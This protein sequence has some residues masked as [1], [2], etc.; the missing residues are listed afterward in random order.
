MCVGRRR[1]GGGE[2]VY[3][4]TTLESDE[5]EGGCVHIMSLCAVFTCVLCLQIN[6]II[7]LLC[8]PATCG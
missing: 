8:K 3:L 4:Q 1:G 6:L 2:L 7:Y 5:S